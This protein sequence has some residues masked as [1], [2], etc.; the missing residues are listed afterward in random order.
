M[1]L[2]FPLGLVVRRVSIGTL[3]LNIGEAMAAL[4]NV[5]QCVLLGRVTNVYIDG[6]NLGWAA[7]TNIGLLLV[8]RKVI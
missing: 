5:R 6:S 8:W 3:M 7:L 2:V 4:N 1:T